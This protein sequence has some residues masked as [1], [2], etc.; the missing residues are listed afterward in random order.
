MRRYKF[1]E[2]NKLLSLL[3]VTIV[4]ISYF[5]NSVADNV[6]ADGYE[7]QKISWV[8]NDDGILNITGDGQMIDYDE[9][10]SPFYNNKDIKEIIIEDGVTSIGSQTFVKC[11]NLTSIYIPKSMVSIHNNAFVDCPNIETINVDSSNYKYENRENCNAIIDRENNELVLGCYKTVIPSSIKTIG[12]GAFNGSEKLNELEFPESIKHISADAFRNTGLKEL[13]ISKTIEKIDEEAFSNCKNLT[14]INVDEENENYTSMD[15]NLYNKDCSNLIQYAIGKEYSCINISEKAKRIGNGAFSGCENLTTIMIPE[16][17]TEIG[18]RA[19]E[20]CLNLSTID[21]PASVSFIGDNA[22]NNVKHEAQLYTYNNYVYDYL[23]NNDWYISDANQC[24][25]YHKGKIKEENH[26][27]TCT[28]NGYCDKIR[29]CETCNKELKRETIEEEATGHKPKDA[30]IE[31]QVPATTDKDGSYDDVVYCSVCG[32]EIS[33]DTHIIKNPV[34]ESQTEIP[35]DLN[36]N[37]ENTTAATEPT[38]QS[39]E[40]KVNENSQATTETESFIG[41]E[42]ES[43]NSDLDDGNIIS[44]SPNIIRRTVKANTL[45]TGE[46]NTSIVTLNSEP[47]NMR[48][49]IPAVLPI[50]VDE[51]NNVMT[52]SNAQI[53]NLSQGQI[54]ITNCVVETLNAWKLVDFDTNFNVVPVDSKQFGFKMQGFKV[55]PN[56]NAFNNQFDV[57]DGNSNLNINYDARLAVQ[58]QNINSENIGKVIFTVSWYN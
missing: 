50:T 22:F 21:I 1:F 12:V 19:F 16:N 57:I 49:V 34:L 9:E 10:D 2:I 20:D 30:V 53:Q 14:L 54:Q 28:E 39:E 52:A 45:S 41:P 24:Y 29:Y 15:G 4:I 5:I 31:N 27:A 42:T 40:N 46:P 8:I 36:G 38:T 3:L 32:E 43:I 26:P 6:Q 23:D 58:S 51:N 55:N 18:D 37:I 35:I 17:I 11:E 25:E 33:R 13:N 44:S 48:V 56:G 47:S 7:N